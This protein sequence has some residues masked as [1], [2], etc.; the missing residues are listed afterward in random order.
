MTAREAAMAKSGEGE[1]PEV[2]PVAGA[3]PSGL[4]RRARRARGAFVSGPQLTRNAALFTDLYEIT[5][6]A[7]YLRER[8]TG[9]ATFSLFARKLPRGRS[10]LVAAGLEDVLN[11][12]QDF[13]FSD[14]A[15][16]YL[17]S[18]DRFDPSFLEF[19]RDLRF[20]GEVRAV[21]EGTVVFQDE[22]LLEITAPIIEA[23]LVET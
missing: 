6:A 17:D 12:L 8:M 10:F 21:P 22:P 3:T 9:P 15:L 14:D 19:L 2:D 4:R 13:H 1:I 18:L 16:S 5:M 20:S 23:Q 11:F 7:S